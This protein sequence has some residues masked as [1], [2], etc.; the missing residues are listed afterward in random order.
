M[1][2]K[3]CALVAVSLPLLA[4]T[5]AF[6]WG[7]EG[8][9]IVA[10]IAEMRLI[11]AAREAVADFLG[12]QSMSDVASW[13]DEVRRDRRETGPWHYVDIPDDQ[14]TYDEARDGQNGNNVVAK[15]TEFANAINDRSLTKQQRTDAL[16]FLI[17]FCGDIHQP[18][19]CSERNK[20]K[21]GN[22]VHLFLLDEPKMT[23]LHAVWDYGILTRAMGNTPISV[24]A[25]AL[26]V[27]ITPDQLREWRTGTPETWANEA[28][29]IA[30]DSVYDGVPPTTSPPQK[31]DQ[32]YVDR[33]I[34]IINT[35]LQKGG[36]RL[37]RILNQAFRNYAATTQPISAVTRPYGAAPPNNNG[38]RTRRQPTTAPAATAAP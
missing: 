26:N 36:V 10:K 5:R 30:H 32:A 33:S 18:L 8:H 29:K 20:D 4:S 14:P 27:R 38:T 7:R 9:A 28:H 13:A 23:N 16:K 1:L 35:Q 24:Y 19:H 37:A 11:P 21:G 25:S 3:L 2:R 17:H 34:P 31:L 6:A 15:I 22:D 12:D